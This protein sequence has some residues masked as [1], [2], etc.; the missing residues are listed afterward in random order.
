LGF[1][2]SDSGG[3]IPAAHRA[4]ALTFFHS[5]VV[6][7]EPT[8]TYSK[9]FGAKFTGYGVGLPMARVY[10]RLAGGDLGLGVLPGYGTDVYLI[11]NR[12]ADSPIPH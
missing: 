9:D 6:A 8:Y 2:V 7:A 5:S 11:L 4:K 3:G 10:A 12:L 1:R